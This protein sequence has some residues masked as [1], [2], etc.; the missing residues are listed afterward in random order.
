MAYNDPMDMFFELKRNQYGDWGVIYIVSSLSL[1]TWRWANDAQDIIR[2]SL[3][4]SSKH[5]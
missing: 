2:T 4:D 5:H 1:S 3:C